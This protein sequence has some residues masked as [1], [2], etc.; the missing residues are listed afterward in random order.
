MKIAEL[1]A[2]LGLD[3]N[4]ESFEK[5][6]ELI[7]GVHHALEALAVFEGV[8]M[9][10]EL[11]ESTTDAAVASKRMGEKLGISA[12]SVQ[13]LGY[14]ADVSGASVEDIQGAM[15]KLALSS[16]KVKTGQEPLV[17]GLGK[18]GIKFSEISKLPLDERLARIADGFADAGPG[19]DKTG[20]SMEIFG[21]SG[22]KL[23]PM[24]NKGADGL[25]ELREEFIATGAQIDDE[26][27]DQF[28]KLEE[29][30][31]KLKYNWIGI[32]NQLVSALLPAIQG[33]ADGLMKWVQANREMIKQRLE[34]VIH[35]IIV[36]IKAA[37]RVVGILVTVFEAVVDVVQLVLEAFNDLV[38]GASGVE[39][40]LVGAAI[41]V[42]AAWLLANLPLIAMLAAIAAVILVVQDLWSWMNG[43]D[44]V[45]KNLYEAF[46]QYLGESGVGRIILG[47]MHSIH[48]VIDAAIEGFHKLQAAADYVVDKAAF[49]KL[50]NQHEREIREQNGDDMSSEEVRAQAEKLAAYDLAKNKKEEGMDD[51]H[52]QSVLAGAGKNEAAKWDPWNQ[53]PLTPAGAGGANSYT[54]PSM[55]NHINLTGVAG[56][57]NE[58]AG[59][60]AT[61]IKGF[62]DDQMRDT[63]HATGAKGGRLP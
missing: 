2:E 42:G 14:A 1:F 49:I 7:E 35:G 5:G 57:P 48:A 11:V 45:L 15:Q 56:S 63:A 20:I 54:A 22:T 16:E 34:Q 50:R 13:Q 19:V 59:S 47:V 40:V 4:K 38:G 62:W 31:K 9:L 33:M 37:A 26:T 30:G 17:T 58:I 36:V 51:A 18:L 21:K 32:K 43:G 29:T 8:K 46:V 39:D 52:L 55:V 6:S 53:V 41:A 3:V 24:L 44:S 61:A 10:G 27:I 23:I 28:E 12:Q 25:A 60:I